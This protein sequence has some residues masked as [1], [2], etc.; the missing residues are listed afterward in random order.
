MATEAEVE[1][2]FHSQLNNDSRARTLAVRDKWKTFPLGFFYSD[3]ISVDLG[4]KSTMLNIL[5]NEHKSLA[6]EHF[7]TLRT[8]INRDT[9]AADAV[10]KIAQISSAA[11]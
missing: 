9:T 8:T 7:E 2:F 6:S 11:Q 5:T 10:T 1:I 4:V 3:E